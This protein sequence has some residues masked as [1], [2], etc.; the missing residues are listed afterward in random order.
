MPLS[1]LNKFEVNVINRGAIAV[2]INKI[3]RGT[4]NALNGREA[5]LHRTG[6]DLNRLGTQL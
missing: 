3:E 2:A 6:I 4:T 1:A 5:S